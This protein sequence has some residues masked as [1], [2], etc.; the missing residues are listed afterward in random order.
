MNNEAHYVPAW[1]ARAP[2]SCA[3]RAP[4]AWPSRG[5]HNAP[6]AFPVP[7]PY[8][9]RAPAPQGT[10]CAP[11]RLRNYNGEK[12]KRKITQAQAM[13]ELVAAV[14]ATKPDN[15]E[16]TI[17]KRDGDEYLYV[18]YSSPTFGF[19]DD[20]EAFFPQSRCVWACV[21]KVAHVFARLLRV[22]ASIPCAVL[23][24]RA[25]SAGPARASTARRRASARVTAT[26]TAS[27]SRRCAWSCRRPAGSPSATERTSL[28]CLW[29]RGAVVL[30]CR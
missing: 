17:I 4:C 21:G 13:D 24:H 30:G 3:A 27:A 6:H 5:W 1:C 22:S 26:S 20:W 7:A 10:K 23:N 19:I 9:R 2:R 14:N 28:A 16:H 25:P 11:P 8:M 15:F 18:E 29:R 12:R